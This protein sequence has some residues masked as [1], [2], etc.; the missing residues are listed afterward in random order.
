MMYEQ[1]SSS[2]DEIGNLSKTFNYMAKT[3]ES[4]DGRAEGCGQKTGGVYSKLCP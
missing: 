1:R 2:R 4:E 3:I